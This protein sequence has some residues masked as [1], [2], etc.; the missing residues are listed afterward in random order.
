MNSLDF[1]LAS[2]SSP[3]PF[4]ERDLITFTKWLQ[5]EIPRFEPDSDWIE[6]LRKRNGGVPRRCIFGSRLID[7]V[8]HFGDFEGPLL[9]GS[10]PCVH[11]AA[12][13]SE[14]FDLLLIP[15]AVL[16]AG[17]L[18]CFDHRDQSVANPPVVIWLHEESEED[19][20][21][22]VPVADS[23]QEF[24]ALLERDEPLDVAGNQD[25]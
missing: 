6:L 17:D 19:E 20:P 11:T 5:R 13:D 1:D 16:F 23:F 25:D 10:V 22:T 14:A 4:D 9:R 3:G 12:W 24:L 18:L 15:F 21:V 2:G 7:R 8:C